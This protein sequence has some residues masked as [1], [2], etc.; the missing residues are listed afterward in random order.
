MA[1]KARVY[2]VSSAS[3]RGMKPHTPPAH[4]E[5]PVH[6]DAIDKFLQRYFKGDE[7]QY[8]E[9]IEN[10]VPTHQIPQR[11]TPYHERTI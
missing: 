2:G 5:I 1:G 6:A 10:I 3:M 9:W 8:Q 11:D 7:Q 4:R